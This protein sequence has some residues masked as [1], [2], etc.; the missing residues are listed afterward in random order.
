MSIVVEETL[1]VISMLLI[2]SWRNKRQSTSCSA[3]ATHVLRAATQQLR[4]AT[5]TPLAHAA[6]SHTLDKHPLQRRYKSYFNSVFSSL[7]GYFT[8]EDFFLETNCLEDFCFLIQ[9]DKISTTYFISNDCEPHFAI[10]NSLYLYILRTVII[11]FI[12]DITYSRND[13]ILHIDK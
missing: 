2:Q 6:S 4:V 10:S 13:F 12:F 11:I 7:K 8:Y 1:I 3:A 9:M 5:K